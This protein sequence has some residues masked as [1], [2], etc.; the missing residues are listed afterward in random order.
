MIE[1]FSVLVCGVCVS[2][3]ICLDLLSRCT[4]QV[5]RTFVSP[6]DLAECG[7]KLELHSA[8]EKADSLNPKSEVYQSEASTARI[9]QT[10]ALQIVRF[11]ALTH[12][13]YMHLPPFIF[14]GLL[15]GCDG[16]THT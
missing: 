8:Q 4:C 7:S 2:D 15:Q 6:A 5:F 16:Q 9:M 1:V 12:Q 3:V 14:V 11:R 10:S 13:H